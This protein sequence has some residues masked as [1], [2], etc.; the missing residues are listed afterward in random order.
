[1]SQLSSEQKQL[2]F[3][4]C[5]GLTSEEQTAEAEAL[6]ASNQEAADIHAK[7]KSTFMLL[8]SLG[9]EVC[10]DELADRTVWRLSSMASSRGRLQQLL[11]SE[12]SKRI[13]GNRI[14]VG[15]ARR[16]ATA[17]I[18]LIAGSVLFNV[19]GYLRYHAQLQQCQS[20]MAG[21]FRGLSHYI[22]DYDGKPPSVAAAAGD[23]WWKVGH[24]GNENHSNTRNV[25]L[26][27]RGGYTQ[28]GDYICPGCPSGKAV[29]VSPS[30]AK[31][32][33]DFP[34]RDS[35]TYSFQVNCQRMKNGQVVCRKVVMA[36][37]NPL[38]E[39]LPS[40]YNQPLQVHLTKNL[41]TL[42]SINHKRHGQ[43]V[44][45]GDG[46][47]QYTKTRLIGTDD[48]YTLQDTD[49]YQGCEIPSCETDF[50]V[51]P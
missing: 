40:D 21:V 45:F 35:V 41:L 43:N 8:D 22:S 23:P 30:E 15:F 3:D 14:W 42:N 4:Y 47:V 46:R 37:W 31:T 50:F 28:T 13:G 2:L 18:F 1:M 12:Q 5:T 20:Q 39:E 17:A 49:V 6:V 10:P 44:L 51:A 48:I 24:Q 7:L 34:C 38:F 25:Y 27:V 29:R 26:L 9:D 16:L 19:L 33:K 32:Y 11:A 36:D